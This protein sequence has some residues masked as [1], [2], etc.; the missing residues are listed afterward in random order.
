MTIIALWAIRR[1]GISVSAFVDGWDN[2]WR[3]FFGIDRP[4]GIWPPRWD[5]FGEIVDSTI[6][7]LFMA[8]LAT[9]L[10][11]AMSFPL[12]FLAARNTTPH[13]ALRIPAR[14]VIVFARSIPDLVFA[15]VFVRA[16]GIGPTAGVLA[17]GLHAIGM[18][19]KLLADAIEETDPGPREAVAATG[20]GWFQQM[21][22]GVVPQV[23]PAYIGICLYR[24]DINFRSAPILGLVGAGGI[25]TL[26]RAYQGNLRWDLFAGV[27]VVIVVVVMVVEAVSAAARKAILGHDRPGARRRAAGLGGFVGDAFGRSPVEARDFDVAQD[28]ALRPPWDR[29]RR[30]LAGFAALGGV[31]VVASVPL[32]QVSGQDLLHGLRFDLSDPGPG[33]LPTVWNVMVRLVPSDLQWLDETMRS[34][35]FETV[36]IGFAS[37][38]IGVPLALPIAYLAA[39]N[40]APHPAIYVVTRG[41]MALVRAIPEVIIAI[42]LIAAVGL[43][44]F[45][46]TIALA[47]GMMGFASK[48]YADSLEEVG[49]G[50]RDGV[51]AVGATRLQEAATGV[52]SQFMPAFVAHSL[53]VLDIAVR[54]GTILGI[55]GAGGIGFYLIQASRTLDFEVV[56]GLIIFIFIVVFAIERLSDWLRVRLI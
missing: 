21:A 20:A 54:A 42:L 46:G 29:H 33:E 18:V 51:R 36:A 47:I 37:T 4:T 41:F 38:A 55:F 40:V 23:V 53:Y 27:T 25:G 3:L 2:L 52:T 5:D 7:T 56:G 30:R 39:R 45:P 14:G 8:I 13:P 11:A 26:L 28:A 48:L 9:A 24:L 31:V 35:M 1:V 22:T 43:G 17:L 19:G 32:S 6:E 50:P 16:F 44:P 15:L 34:A 49:E 10:A 12:G